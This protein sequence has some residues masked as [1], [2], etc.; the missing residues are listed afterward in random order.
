MNQYQIVFAD[1]KKPIIDSRTN[2]PMFKLI[3]NKKD[4][5]KLALIVSSARNQN[6]IAIA[7]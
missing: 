5:D 4:A 6:I 2:N 1:T 7:V 3:D